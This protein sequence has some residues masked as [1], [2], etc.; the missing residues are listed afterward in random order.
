[1][2]ESRV[3]K[4][5][6]NARVNL[7]CYFASLVVAFFSRK[8]FID[9]L[10]VDFIGLTG[11]LYSL[12]SFLNL[13]EL[14]IASA[15]GYVLYKPLFENDQTKIN[16]IISV[17]GYIY[18]WIGIII[19]T[20]ACIVACFLPS[21]F[22][23][24]EFS[25]GI[26]Y[27]AYFSFLASS[28]IGYFINYRQTLL[29]A[30]QRNYVIAGYYQ[31]ATATKVIVQMLLTLYFQSYVIWISIELSFGI[32][33]SFV[34][35]WRINKTYPWLKSEIRLGKELFKKYPDITKYTKQLFVHKIGTFTQSQ[36]LPF[37]IYSFVSLSMV[38]LYSNYTIITN[39]ISGLAG[40]VLGG[41]SAGIGNLIAEGNREKILKV[42]QEMFA[43]GFLSAS[44]LAAC[45]LFLINPFVSLWLGAEYVLPDII[46]YLIV[47][48]LFILQT[49]G[50]TDMFLFG[51]G[52]FYDTWAPI[53]EVVI[54]V[55]MAIALGS[56]Y[57]LA[58]V[59]M[60]PLVS[61]FLIVYLWKPFFLFRKGMQRGFLV[62]WKL[63]FLH[64]IPAAGAYF[65]ANRM[66]SCIS[67]QADSSYLNWIICAVLFTLLYVFL[68]CGGLCLTSAG[69][70]SFLLRFKHRIECRLNFND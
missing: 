4:S 68:T 24:L 26:L 57:G 5:L 39:K 47:F 41:A 67:L 2:L 38:T 31:A 3:K 29:G 40:A 55:I 33:Y 27:F 35:N 21:I 8:I 66:L 37:L 15:I 30:D 65:L 59:L 1:M 18:R 58:G 69:M 22:P 56:I 20:I 50:T 61:L 54:F 51:F 63:Y 44:I 19:L 45:L 36:L 9:Q 6:L 7:I 64:L 62:Y 53:V 49:R 43:V 48:Q 70:R 25:Y 17:F 46:L 13:A 60:G 14:G 34:L 52:L 10:G 12:L 28:L 42:Y 32:I 16:E 11:A 23:N